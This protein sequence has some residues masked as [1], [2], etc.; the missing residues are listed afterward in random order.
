MDLVSHT[1]PARGVDQPLGNK[2][3]RQQDLEHTSVTHAPRTG[4][5]AREME[6]RTKHNHASM[7]YLDLS[8]LPYARQ[9]CVIG[10]INSD[11]RDQERRRSELRKMSILKAKHDNINNVTITGNTS[12]QEKSSRRSHWQ[13]NLHP[14]FT[15]NVLR[16]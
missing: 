8:I 15:R 1:W 16:N 6:Y 12:E 2:T 14:D 10:T 3:S 11:V 9:L 5:N 7:D 4:K 13:P